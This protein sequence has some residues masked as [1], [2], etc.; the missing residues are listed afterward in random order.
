MGLEEIMSNDLIDGELVVFEIKETS[1]GEEQEILSG[2]EVVFKIKTI[3]EWKWEDL[4]KCPICWLPIVK[5]EG[6]ER[7]N[8]VCPQCKNVFHEDH[9]MTWLR[10]KEVCPLCSKRLRPEDLEPWIPP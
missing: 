1:K 9:I 2:E 6:E 7:R 10:D 8:V 5:E 4:P 3:G